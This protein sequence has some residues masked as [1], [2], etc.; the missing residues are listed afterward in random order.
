VTPHLFRHTAA[1]YLLEA[2]IEVNVIRGWLGG[3]QRRAQHARRTVSV[4]GA[5]PDWPDAA[6]GI[7]LLLLNLQNDADEREHR[8]AI[9]TGFG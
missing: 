1:V 2:G 8:D 4:A 9:T 7:T 3:L 6:R 5:G